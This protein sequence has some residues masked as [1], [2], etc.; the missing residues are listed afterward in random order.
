MGKREEWIST[1]I[2]NAIFRDV[3]AQS[4]ALLQ[5]ILVFFAIFR[6]RYARFEPALFRKLRKDVW[7]LDEE[8]Y[9]E[10]FRRSGKKA[11]LKPLGD[12]LGYSGSVR[13]PPNHPIPSSPQHY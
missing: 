6:L 10:S 2:L 11:G 5:R 1:S 7:Q 12:L 13:P 8:E 9:H 3:H 4:L